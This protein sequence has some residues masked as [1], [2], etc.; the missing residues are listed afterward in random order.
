M[1]V[2]PDTTSNLSLASFT[3]TAGLVSPER[4]TPAWDRQ[5]RRAVEIAYLEHQRLAGPRYGVTWINEYRLSDEVPNATPRLPWN[6]LADNLPADEDVGSVLL[7]PGEH[8]FGTKYATQH[9]TM[10]LEPSIY[11][12]ALMRDVI[13]FGGRI[14]I[15]S[16]ETPRDLMS[17]AEPLIVNCTGLGAKALFGDQEL[18]PVKG[19]LTVL[20]PQPEVTYMVGGM[21]PRSDGIILNGGMQQRDAWSLDVDEAFQEGVI[22]QF[23]TIFDA[24][25]SPIAGVPLTRLDP[26]GSAPAVE[27]FFGR[28]S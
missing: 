2:P 4:W 8:P 26:P 16:F 15:R 11:L 12:D 10:R 27:S 19:Q 23:K 9:P 3:P 17:L 21:L 22:Q 5:F 18:V 28:G 24:M 13:G 20:V 14:V 6:P 7:G 1:T 25:R